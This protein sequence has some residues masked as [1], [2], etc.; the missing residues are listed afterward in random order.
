MLHERV[1]GLQSLTGHNLVT[2]SY[3]AEVE[4]FLEQVMPGIRD[5]ILH[6]GQAVIKQPWSYYMLV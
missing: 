1:L 4:A 3:T 6:F 5:L 2:F